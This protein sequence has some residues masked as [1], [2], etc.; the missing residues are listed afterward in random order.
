[1]TAHRG[2][3]CHE[4]PAGQRWPAPRA[5]E[6]RPG[7]LVA[8]L[9]AAAALALASPGCK[10]E[11]VPVPRA[12]ESAPGNAPGAPGM[13]RAREP[14]PG[15]A[16]AGEAAPARG[17]ERS[18]AP[19]KDLPALPSRYPAPPRLV[20]IG[21][22]HGDLDATRRALILA[23]A[24]DANDRW[25][26]KDLVVVQ[27]GDVLDRGDG[28]QAI[29]D[30]LHR[31][32]GEA[33]AAGGAVHMLLG[34]HETMNALGDFRY[35]TSG[36]FTDFADVPGL[37]VDAP[38]LA[39][40]PPEQ[41]ARA[42]AFAPGSVYARRLAAS[43][44]VIQVGDTVFAHGGVLPAW[45]EYGI[46]RMNAELRCWLAGHGPPPD[47]LAR[48]DNPLWSRDYSQPPE[49]C[50]ALTAALERLGATR[51]VVAHTPQPMGIS[52]ACGQRVWRID[53]GMAAHYGGPTQILE[54]RGSEVR[55]LRY[56][57]AGEASAQ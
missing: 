44:A 20:A 31:L 7:A 37:P 27:A 19:C 2:T 17:G 52:T 38:A 57:P 46:E 24:I 34:N 26:G 39:G 40:L 33:A 10:G 36:G 15:G 3:R 32:A 11:P 53:T 1:M 48:P 6:G 30:L 47:L 18:E 28:E 29:L 55:V 25:I 12:R 35:V 56:E 14:A 45:A 4:R 23:G 51:M 16:R 22:V 54:I 50:D 21:D 8:I 42:A 9:M 49:R 13:E 43:N 5:R 41:R